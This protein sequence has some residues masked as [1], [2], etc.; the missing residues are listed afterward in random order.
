[1]SFLVLVLGILL[2]LGGAAALYSGYANV[3]VVRGW[4]AVIAGTTALSA[5]VMTIGLSFILRCL[6]RLQ[7]FLEIERGLAGLLN[8]IA[9]NRDANYPRA[10]PTGFEGSTANG[11]RPAAL[12]A[13]ATSVTL[14]VRASD[15]GG[16][17]SAEQGAESRNEPSMRRADTVG[18]ID[19]PAKAPEPRDGPGE[20]VSSLG[21]NVRR[22]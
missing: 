6:V 18:G 20:A 19:T 1:M 5:G 3:E 12:V 15:A 2:S 4:T 11:G 13:A 22:A 14:E 17:G 7:A 16:D 10:R 8:E 21:S 9:L